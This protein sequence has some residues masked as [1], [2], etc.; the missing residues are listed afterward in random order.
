MIPTIIQTAADLEALI[1]EARSVACIAIDTEFVWERTYYPKL[2][3]VQIG[4]SENECY[5]IDAAHLGDITPLG[6]ILSDPYIVK[7]LHDAHQDLVILNRA[8]GAFPRMVFDTQ[9]AAGFVGLGASTSLG[10][11]VSQLLHINLSK[12]ETRT[13]WLKRPLLK[14]QIEYALDD[15]RYLPAVHERIISRA[16]EKNVEEW[17][18]DELRSYDN[19]ESYHERDSSVLFHRIK[20]IKRFS[21]KELAILRELAGW[22]E[23]KARSENRPREH[24]I[25]DKTLAALA[26][27]KPKALSRLKPLQGLQQRKVQQYG[28]EIIDLIKKGAET[29][30]ENC[31]HAFRQSEDDEILNARIDFAM[32]YIKGQCIEKGIDSSLIGSRAEIVEFMRDYTN[33]HV[34][35]H[36]LTQGWRNEFIVEKL[37]KLLSGQRAIW[38]NPSTGLP[39]ITTDSTT[40]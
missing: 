5:I 35:T 1:L 29:P 13:N 28:R 8:T 7:I 36:R 11:L 33:G 10:S 21:P 38:L 32:A 39:Q 4:I 3:V 40:F 14:K 23:E 34:N 17:L 31:P 26:Q 18:W 9:C 24:I 12:T 16:R 27:D 30:P 6:S 25:D 2:G 37:M 15:V 19:E 20:G 22:R